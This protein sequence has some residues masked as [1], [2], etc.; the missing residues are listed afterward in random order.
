LSA[1]RQTAIG[2]ALLFLLAGGLAW[3][4]ISVDREAKPARAS[5]GRI[6]ALPGPDLQV[7]EKGR[8]RGDRPAIVLIHGWTASMEYWSRVAPRLAVGHRVVSVDLIGHGGSEKP[9][10]HGAYSMENQ[11]RQVA[12][13]LRRLRI[14][15]AIVVGHSMGGSVATALAERHRPPM[16]GVVVVDSEP[17]LDSGKDHG[18][19]GG[20]VSFA[21]GRLSCFPVVGELG[22]RLAPD[23]M[24]RR[25]LRLG[26]AKGFDVPDFAVES[27]RRS[28]YTA[29]CQS[30]RHS[31]DYVDE[32]SLATR[33]AASGVPILAIFG[34]KEQIA[35]PEQSIRAY[36]RVPG[37]RV[38]TIAD[39][40]HSPNV[41]R[42]ATTAR[43]I[44]RFVRDLER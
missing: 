5:I 6:L 35:E 29:I 26:F 17:D 24:V 32:R 10:D 37:A 34:A 11:A 44:L 18:P 31:S 33:L 41:E 19:I 40:G 43:L 15:R 7:G 8:A 21:V 12:L 20:L 36:R 1:R 25:A 27:Y 38:A 39:A 2:L 14:R 4:T 42:P 16:T 28:T 30:G 9:R 3:N 22:R 23:F 13:A